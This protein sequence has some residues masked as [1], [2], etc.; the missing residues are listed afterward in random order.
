[1]DLVV[2]NALSLA[3]FAFYFIAAI[4]YGVKRNWKSSVLMVAF[5]TVPWLVL[6]CVTRI[7]LYYCID[8]WGV[9]ITLGAM[10]IAFCRTCIQ[11]R[12][13][14]SRLIKHCIPAG[15]WNPIARWLNPMISLFRFTH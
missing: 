2:V 12:V 11:T 1:M 10:K 7:C 15:L 4:R 5:S 13:I 6:I 9:W 8:M 3:A 14:F